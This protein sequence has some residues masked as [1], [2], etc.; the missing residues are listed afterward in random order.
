MLMG[1]YLLLMWGYSLRIRLILQHA[2]NQYVPDTFLFGSALLF[3]VLL[4]VAMP[5]LSD[6]YARFIWDGRLLVQGINPFRYLPVELMAEG[7]APAGYV[8]PALYQ[9]LNSPNYYTVYPPV[10][11]AF[12]A[13][14]AWVSPGNLGGSVVAL[15]VPILLAEGGT[16]WLMMRLLRQYGRNPNLALLYGLNP[17]VILELTGNVHFEAI[18]IF[19]T[20]LA[21]YLWQQRQLALS[22]GAL[23]LAIATKLLPLLALPLLVSYLGWRRGIRYSALV[24][25]FTGLLFVPFFNLPLLL[26]ML[27]SIDLYFRKFE[28]NASVYYLV[29]LVGFWLMGFNVLGRVGLWLSLLTTAGLL[30]IAFR[31]THP[32]QVRLLWMLTLYFAM[33]TTVHPWYVTSLVAAA[34]FVSARTYTVRYVL[35]WSALVWLSYSAYQTAPFRENG[36]L[37][38]LEY[39]VVFFLFMFDTQRYLLNHRTHAQTPAEV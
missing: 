29:R 24:L 16:L 22:A 39:G 23:S 10:N 33:A 20:L 21:T 35:V 25:A 15:R 34:V 19:F 1:L 30:T 27:E 7:V 5:A 38:L 4:L 26:N 17:L 32:V 12:F 14:A 8:D 11:Q 2:D 31:R 37:L 28:F 18:M 6:D 36:Q 9:L 3:R 13:L